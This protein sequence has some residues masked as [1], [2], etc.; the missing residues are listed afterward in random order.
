[1]TILHRP[2]DPATKAAVACEWRHAPFSAPWSQTRDLLQFEAAHLTGDRRCDVFVEVDLPPSAI[3]LDGGIRANARPPE[4][5]VVAVAVPGTRHGDLRLVSA[6]Y[7]NR[8]H[9]AKYWQHN[10]RAVALTLQALRA[11]DRWGAT[12][13]EQYRGFAALGTGGP[14]AMGSGV[15]PPEATRLLAHAGPCSYDRA[16]PYSAD[17]ARAAFRLAAKT[18]HPDAGGDPEAFRR[19]VEARDL[20]TGGL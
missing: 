4:T 13:G 5:P 7:G 9:L 2:L 19:L 17:E 1:M 8:Y 11:V 14:V 16:R 18:A 15:T 3:R 10:V 20:L 12:T 6:R